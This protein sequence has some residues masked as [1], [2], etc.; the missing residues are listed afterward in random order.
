M[1]SLNNN[2]TLECLKQ[3]DIIT[4][5]SVLL[6]HYLWRAS[7]KVF[8]ITKRKKI[9]NRR[10]KLSSRLIDDYGSD[11]RV[12]PDS[13][14]ISSSSVIGTWRAPL[15][16]L[17]PDCLSSSMAYFF[18]LFFYFLFCLA[19]KSSPPHHFFLCNLEQS[20]VYQLNAHLPDFVR[21]VF[22]FCYYS[23][24]KSRDQTTAISHLLK[25]SFFFSFLSPLSKTN[26]TWM[27]FLFTSLLFSL[28]I[29]PSS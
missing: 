20:F 7:K 6:P 23:N 15:T 13:S 4:P 10:A 24:S 2:E 9:E 3:S 26:N 28:F 17:A 27:L 8:I 5:L 18:F 16:C 21:V 14:I 19:A 22:F 1:P 25:T 12:R 11:S 29:I